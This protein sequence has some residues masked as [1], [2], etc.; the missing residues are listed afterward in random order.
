MREAS[1]GAGR[2]EFWREVW[3]GKTPARILMNFAIRQRVQ[4]RGRVADLGG[5]KNPSYWRFLDA[6]GVEL[7]R[8]DLPNVGRP[9]VA[10][11]LEDCLPFPANVFDAVLLF[12]VL[13]HVYAGD[14]LLAEIY[15]VLQP[16]GRLYLFV[17]F[18]VQVHPDP[19]D[20]RRYTGLALARMF[21]GVG[22]ASWEITPVGE[23][24]QSIVAAA[25]PLLFVRPLRLL[26]LMAAR[27]GDALLNR[28]DE[29]HPE[30]NFRH[31]VIGYFASVC[32]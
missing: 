8:V 11:S 19:E 12:N 29:G 18:L 20:Y 10:A 9:D 6:S 21:D 27:L 28:L 2:G 30:W 23:A 17:P 1:R 3:R 22:F 13:E 26:A 25:Y 4:L 32:K 15:R 7:I 31:W 24:C 16:G 5:G 14:Q